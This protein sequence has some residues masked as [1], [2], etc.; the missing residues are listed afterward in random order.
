MKVWK[1]SFFA[2]CGAILLASAGA[3]AAEIK[4]ISSVGMRGALEALQ[5]QFEKATHN[6]LAITFGT[7][8]PLKRQIDDGATF[9]VVLL[10]P[11]MVADLAKSGKVSADSVVNVAKSGLA[12]ASRKDAANV[13]ISTP[14]ALKRTL[15][16][17]KGVAYSKEGQSGAAAVKLIET[18]GIT[19]QMKSHVVVETRPG[20]GVLS[21]LDGKADLGFSLMS[22]VLASPEAKLVGPVPAELQTYVVFAAGVASSAGDAAAARSFVDFLRGAGVQST[23]TKVGMDTR[24]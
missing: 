21:V 9:D 20:G 5:P 2:A 1:S 4:V 17:A 24:F 13:D 8:V 18:L 11:P 16:A 3:P 15:L 22:E 12:L 10:P 14:E 6:K 23:F 19:E 7:S